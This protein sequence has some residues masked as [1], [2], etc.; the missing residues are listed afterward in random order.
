LEKPFDNND[1]LQH[2]E[3][4][5]HRYNRERERRIME[6][7]AFEANRFETL[8][9]VMAGMVH[10]LGTPLSVLEGQIEF[11]K[12]KSE[13]VDLPKR[14][15]T[16]QAQVHHCCDMVRNTMGF[17][18]S[19]STRGMEVSLSHVVEE[20]LKVGGHTLRDAKV[21]VQTTFSAEPVICVG[22]V[23]LIRQAV[24]NL[25]NNACQALARREAPREIHIRT[26][27]ED[28]TVCLSVTDNGEGIPAMARDRIFDTFYTTKGKEGTGLGLAVVRSV[29]TRHGG[30]VSL[31]QA[32][33]GGAEFTLR[34]PK[35]A[36]RQLG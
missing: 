26:W 33:G 27:A 9:R 12:I 23:V 30:Q 17:M 15:E 2:V 11:L 31:G 29:M 18:R 32:P 22:E 10:D 3:A 36:T 24:L 28:T 21:T 5:L 4:A 14:L 13:H 8:G 6:E 25:I 34:F 1:M 7:L 16:M 19:E 35:S 20:C